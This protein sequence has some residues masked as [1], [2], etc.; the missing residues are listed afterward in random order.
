[1]KRLLNNSKSSANLPKVVAAE[2]EY[3]GGGWYVFLGEFSDGTYFIADFPYWDLRI[4][5]EDP[6]PTYWDDFEGAGYPEW[7]EA[8]LIKDVDS[9]TTEA[10][11]NDMFDWILKNTPE[12]NYNSGDIEHMR[13]VN[14]DR[15]N[16]PYV[17]L[18]Y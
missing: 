11:F 17:Q 9:N 5:N 1:M 14:N 16:Y 15:D 2:A 4:V 18:D 13:S 10:F 3:T 7:Q 8:H 6:R 12:G